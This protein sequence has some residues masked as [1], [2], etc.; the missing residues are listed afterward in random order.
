MN[1]RWI[2]VLVCCGVSTAFLPSLII[3]CGGGGEYLPPPLRWFE[4]RVPGRS[5]GKI[6][7]ET[8]TIKPP[9]KGF[10][11]L[12][13]L[14]N[15]RAKIGSSRE[16]M[17]ASVDATLAAARAAFADRQVFNTLQDWRDLFDAN[18][19]TP[20]EMAEYVKKRDSLFQGS[21]PLSPWQR[22]EW[23]KTIKHESAQVEAWI[24]EVKNGKAPAGLLPHYFY[25]AGAAAFRQ[26]D[27]VASEAAFRRVVD[28][29]PD[30]PK[31][32]AAL[33]MVGRSAFSQTI[34]DFSS[35]ADPKVAMDKAMAA[36]ASYRTKYPKGRYLG[37]VL[38]WEGGLLFRAGR[39]AEA[40]RC[41]AQQLVATDHPELA[42]GAIP[43][44][45]KCFR[46]LGKPEELSSALKDLL[47]QPALVEALVYHVLWT[48][49]TYALEGAPGA[50]SN[51]WR[52]AILRE[53]A[54]VLKD[55]EGHF[56]GQV[57]QPRFVAILAQ[58]LSSDG[59]QKEALAMLNK[60]GPGAEKIE[61]WAFAR[62]LVLER[63][64]QLE[65]AQ[66]AYNYFIK[67]FPKSEWNFD[68]QSHLAMV[69]SDLGKAD[70]AI[71]TLSQESSPR[72]RSDEE[73][74]PASLAELSLEASALEPEL[75][76]WT[77]DAAHK[78]REALWHFAPVEQLTRMLTRPDVSP[79]EATDMQGRLGRALLSQRRYH[80]AIAYLPAAMTEALKLKDLSAGMS[81][82][83]RLTVA[84]VWAGQR[85]KWLKQPARG[86]GLRDDA[87][88]I[89]LAI[90]DRLARYDEL[91]HAVDL[92]FE[93]L[94][95][96]KAKKETQKDARELILNAMP[97]LARS[98]RY[99]LAIAQKEDW[100]GAS[101][102][103]W[104]DLPKGDEGQE[105]QVWWSFG[106]A[107]PY[108]AIADWEANPWGDMDWSR[109][110]WNY[111]WNEHPDYIWGTPKEFMP[112]LNMNVYDE[113]SGWSWKE[114]ESFLA[115]IAELLAS[116]ESGSCARLAKCQELLIKLQTVSS[117]NAAF[118][119]NALQDVVMV[120][121]RN[122]VSESAR[123]AFAAF[124]MK[125]LCN[126]SWGYWGLESKNLPVISDL[127][128]LALLAQTKALPEQVA[129]AD[130][131]DA[132]EISLT[133]NIRV[134]RSLT[135]P[136]HPT[137]DEVVKR[138]TEQGYTA[139]LASD[140]ITIRDWSHVEQLAN[141]FLTT[142]ATSTK[143][144]AV[145]VHLVRAAYRSR[146]PWK[147]SELASW[148]ALGF[149]AST[150][151]FELFHQQ[152]NWDPQPVQ[153]ATFAYRKEFPKG[154]L[155]AEVDEVEGLVLWR[156][157]DYTKALRFA[158]NGMDTNHSADQRRSAVTLLVHVLAELERPEHRAACLKAIQEVKESHAVLVDFAA[159]SASNPMNPLAFLNHFMTSRFA[160][161]G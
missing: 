3:A 93:I 56:Q 43:M 104:S 78:A 151:R 147:M 148:S 106:Q 33:F 84:Q 32:E 128:L 154:K 27:D 44:C 19:V 9:A 125:C 59:R 21:P 111:A 23:Q 113:D 114:R 158:C 124:R 30:H 46:G 8:G 70:E 140:G 94:K 155:A 76:V 109:S 110:S 136:L 29:F 85:G 67:V 7:L 112:E 120:V 79:E 99:H 142:H 152:Q 135:K 160:P 49:D 116:F 25:L 80:E 69:L 47:A 90:D 73:I 117:A 87:S 13:E 2:S 139:D 72:E 121:S 60:A 102:Q 38:G 97:V 48:S 45:E 101:Q 159:K 95:D 28:E 18:A 39:S 42:R 51:Q 144:E 52:R 20:A 10:D 138:A 119:T 150:S 54:E 137:D 126:A 22:E 34:V 161:G 36:F 96:R 86:Q 62:A 157:G 133:A 89:H 26:A 68:A 66:A 41:Y 4:G 35:K 61:D 134:P 129:L 53:F 1:S 146:R 131:W 12:T 15:I 107:K 6:L 63:S 14:F 58:T 71:E 11:S 74:Y 103:L 55:A 83:N 16:D 24:A 17:L 88:V 143:R 91:Q 81:A 100:S 82:E 130:M 118:L 57:W 64:Q 123:A 77:S 98:S 156:T 75:N 115:S 37:D 145:Y 105:R 127:D 149:D 141:A 5:L 122:D 50:S 31:A 153:R 92:C 65:K 108:D 40:L 132:L